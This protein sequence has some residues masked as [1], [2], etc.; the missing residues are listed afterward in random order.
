M[1][2]KMVC[3]ALGGLGGTALF[4]VALRLYTTAKYRGEMSSVDEAPAAHV[5]IVFGAGLTRTGQ[6]TPV[7]YDRVATAADLYRLGKVDK[8][9]LSGD[10]RFLNYNEPGAMRQ[11]ALTLGVPD[12]ALVLD[13]AGRSTYDTCYRA[14][15]IFGVTRATLVTQNF[16]LPRA[17]LLCE[18]LGIQATGV[19]ADRRDYWL[20]SLAWWNLRET[21]AT[22]NALVEL[23]ITRP[24]PVLGDPLPIP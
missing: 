8:L 14:K 20:N 11:A 22:A 21:L 19:S 13:Y 10:N 23:F 1:K 7:L 2:K 4:L 6:P 18:A 15:A 16:H 5:A 3:I 9:L 12:A 17:L 24:K